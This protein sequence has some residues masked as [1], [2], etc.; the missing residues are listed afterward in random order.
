MAVHTLPTCI[1]F[2]SCFERAT[3]TKPITACPLNTK[4][5]TIHTMG[6]LIRSLFRKW[7]LSRGLSRKREYSGIMQHTCTSIYS[8]LTCQF[9]QNFANVKFS[10]E[11]RLECSSAELPNIWH[12][13]SW[14]ADF[15]W[16]REN[17]HF[18]S[19]E[20]LLLS[21]EFHYLP[22]EFVFS[23][24]RILSANLHFLSTIF[25]ILRVEFLLIFLVQNLY[26]LSTKFPFSER[27]ILE[28]LICIHLY[29][30]ICNKPNI[31]L[32]E[33]AVFNR[34]DHSTYSPNIQNTAGL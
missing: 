22:A 20:F 16:D 28:G 26:F 11:F 34:R 12:R 3:S 24:R 30:N 31:L 19:A 33:W 23:E 9:L 15:P 4:K 1:A 10:T 7:L 25:L 5:P 18:L 17:F 29:I 8:M 21:A 32:A 2:F 13:K 27:R 14:K 6:S